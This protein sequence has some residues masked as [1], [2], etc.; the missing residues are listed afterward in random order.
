MGVRCYIY[1]VWQMNI[2]L[3]RT[4]VCGEVG[5]KGKSMYDIF[6]AEC[7]LQGQAAR[8]PEDVCDAA[9]DEELDVP[10]VVGEESVVGEVDGE[11][12][13]VGVRRLVVRLRQRLEGVRQRLQA[14]DQLV[15]PD[16]L[17]HLQ[18]ICYVTKRKL[19]DLLSSSMI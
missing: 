10:G 1:L 5:F 15:A 4:T 9:G 7:H 16:V 11:R 13:V 8:S 2:Q 6:K 14:P 12:R 18:M 19:V 17:R 3:E